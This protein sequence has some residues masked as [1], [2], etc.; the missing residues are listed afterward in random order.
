MLDVSSETVTAIASG[1]VVPLRPPEREKLE[2]H[3]AIMG[4]LEIR[5]GYE[6]HEIRLALDTP[7]STLD[8]RTASVVMTTGTDGLRTVH[9]AIAEIVLP[10]ERGGASR[11]AGREDRSVRGEGLASPG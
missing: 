10:A 6:S 1:M 11:H 4:R 2:L 3:C 7:L 9:R 8:G 5:F